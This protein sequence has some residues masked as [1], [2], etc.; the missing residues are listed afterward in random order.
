MGETAPLSGAGHPAP[1]PEE[2][3]RAVQVVRLDGPSPAELAGIDKPGRR[4]RQVLIQASAAGVTF[5]VA[6]GGVLGVSDRSGL[7]Y[8]ACSVSLGVC[9]RRG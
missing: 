8:A 2:H 6:S 5:P 7:S 3:R 4:D 9:V 1:I